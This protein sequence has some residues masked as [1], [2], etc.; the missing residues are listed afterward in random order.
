MTLDALVQ[1]PESVVE[2]VPHAPV[3][4]APTPPSASENGDEHCQGNA[5]DAAIGACTVN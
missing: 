3:L 4:L 5:L 2:A 1:P